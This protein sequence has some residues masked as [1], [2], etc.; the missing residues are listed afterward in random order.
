MLRVHPAGPACHTGAE[1]C[2]FNRLD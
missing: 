1:S 2:F